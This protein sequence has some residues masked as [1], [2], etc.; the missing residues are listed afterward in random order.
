MLRQLRRGAP[1]TL[2]P[3]MLRG[4]EGMAIFPDSPHAD[5]ATRPA[6]P[7]TVR[8]HRMLHPPLFESLM[9]IRLFFSPQLAAGFCGMHDC[10]L[11]HGREIYWLQEEGNGY[12]NAA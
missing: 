3:V 11:F 1:D 2:Y 9:S 8:R 10:S 5:L 7:Q 6:T 12:G 4:I